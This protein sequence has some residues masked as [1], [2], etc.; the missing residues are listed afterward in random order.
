MKCSKGED[1]KWI[2]KGGECP[3]GYTKAADVTCSKEGETD[4][5]FS[6]SCPSGWTKKSGETKDSAAA[7][8]TTV[9]TVAAVAALAF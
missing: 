5:K 9:A 7:V 4:T 2:K 3:E 6:G 1:S 8:A